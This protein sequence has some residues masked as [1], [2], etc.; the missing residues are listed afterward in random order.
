MDQLINA[1]DRGGY[2]VQVDFT[3]ENGDPVVPTAAVWSLTDGNGAAVNGRTDV[4]IS[5]LA[6]TIY[7]ALSGADLA[8]RT[9]RTENIRAL[10]V[11]ATY[12]SSLTGTEFPLNK[13]VKFLISDLPGV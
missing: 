5:S 4:A 13:A 12:L 9:T 10:V 11:K 2:V 3:D 1:R 6:S 8:A 7:I